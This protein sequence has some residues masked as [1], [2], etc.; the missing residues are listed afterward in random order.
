MT[1]SDKDFKIHHIDTGFCRVNYK[2]INSDGQT[3]FYCL[4]D[5]GDEVVCYRSSK[6]FEPDYQINYEKHRFEVPTG[7]TD[8]EITVRK[9]LT[10]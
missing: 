8:I 3:I 10:D 2:A 1:K 5:E 4:Q 9:Y 7:N 6:D